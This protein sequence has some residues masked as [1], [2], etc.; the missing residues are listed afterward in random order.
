MKKVLVVL[1]VCSLVSSLGYAKTREVYAKELLAK[2]TEYNIAM[3]VKLSKAKTEKDAVSII[4]AAFPESIKFGNEIADF[5]VMN[6]D[7]QIDDENIDLKDEF[8]KSQDAVIDYSMA[9][10]DA[11]NK[12]S[13][14]EDFKKSLADG[15]QKILSSPDFIKLTYPDIPA[16]EKKIYIVK[17]SQLDTPEGQAKKIINDMT[18]A[19]ETSSIKLHDSANGGDAAKALDDLIS[20]MTKLSAENKAFESKYPDYVFNDTNEKL[21]G[22][23]KRLNNAS[24]KWTMILMRIKIKYDDSEVFKKALEDIDASMSSGDQ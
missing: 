21:D 18:A 22:E 24:N 13:A 16:Y 20:D 10:A 14:S 19:F 2:M 23:Y 4:L 15:Y 1:T 12:Y 5:N 17:P 11:Q 3:T 6:T 9:V 7:Y 8:A